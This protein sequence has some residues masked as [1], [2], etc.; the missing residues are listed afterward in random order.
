MEIAIQ[1]EKYYSD[2]VD[3]ELPAMLYEDT[4]YEDGAWIQVNPSKF[5]KQ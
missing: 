1:Y 2:E 5:A 4:T 3:D